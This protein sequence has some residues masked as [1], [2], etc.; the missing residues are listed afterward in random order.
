MND[1]PTPQQSPA[2]QPTVRWIILAAI[3]SV[4]IFN[5]WSER[6]RPNVP[7]ANASRPAQAEP[8]ADKVDL[9]LP[10]SNNTANEQVSKTKPADPRKTTSPKQ[11]AA[12]PTKPGQPRVDGLK[13]HDVVI[14]NQ[15]DE[16][17]YRGT[18]DLTQTLERIDAERILTEFRHDGIEF[19]NLVPRQVSLLGLSH[20]DEF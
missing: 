14:R 20:S 6:K 18:V 9:E 17:V 8:A 10:R 7:V 19:K 4:L 1:D 5:W 11:T 13:V 16:V 15:D 2:T 3:A 12:Q